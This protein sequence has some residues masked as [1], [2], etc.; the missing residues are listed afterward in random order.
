MP[1]KLHPPRAGKT[2]NF[3]IR[4]TYLGVAVDRSAGTPKR[5]IA[6]Q[7]LK[8]LEEQIERGEYPPKPAVPVGKTFLARPSHI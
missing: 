4:G 5:H 1:L 8:R 2:P 3:S 7:Q 6:Q